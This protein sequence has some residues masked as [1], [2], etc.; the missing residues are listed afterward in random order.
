MKK[1]LGFLLF[2]LLSFYSFAETLVVPKIDDGTGFVR[3][4]TTNDALVNASGL[5]YLLEGQ[6][7]GGTTNNRTKEVY[8]N[9]SGSDSTGNGSFEKPY[10]TIKYAFSTNAIPTSGVNDKWAIFVSPGSYTE[11]NPIT[12]RPHVNL[13]AIGDTSSTRVLANDPDANLFECSSDSFIYGF[14]LLNASNAAA[15]NMT[16]V[17]ICVVRHTS[18]IDCDVGFSMSNQ[19]A[20]ADLDNITAF[21]IGGGTDK[22]IDITAGKSTIKDVAVV[23]DSDVNYLVYATGSNTII[24]IANPVSA[25]A[26]LDYGI[27]AS[28]VASIT[29]SGGRLDGG[30]STGLITAV[31]CDGAHIDVSSLAI[32]N[33]Q[34]GI[35]TTGSDDMHAAAISIENCSTGLLFTG[36]TDAFLSGTSLL[37]CDTDLVTVG[38]GVIFTG[39]GLLLDDNKLVLD[40]LAKH[41]FSHMSNREGDEGL[42]IKGELQVG[43]PEFP[44]ETVMGSGDSYTR[45]MMFYTYDGSTYSNAV[46]AATSASG[47]TVGFPNTNANSAMY[48]AS[49]IVD[50]SGDTLQHPGVKV[51]VDTP[52]TM[53][54]GGVVDFQYY[55]TNDTWESFNYMVTDSGGSYYPYAKNAFHTNGS[56]QIRYDYRMQ[57]DWKKNDPAGLGYSNY[58]ARAVIVSNIVASPLLEQVKLHTDRTEINSD[59][60]MEY[61]GNGRPVKKLPWNVGLLQ[62]VGNTMGAGDV[63][64]SIAKLGVGGDDVEFDSNGDYT[65]FKSQLPWDIDTSCPIGFAWSWRPSATG[66]DVW[67]IRWGKTTEGDEI[68]LGNQAGTDNNIIT[69]TNSVTADLQHWESVN[70]DISDMLSRR[71]DG[72]GDTL[73]ISIES[74]TSSGDPIMLDVSGGYVRWSEGA[75]ITSFLN[76]K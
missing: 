53:G 8:V 10:K 60:F 24:D 7:G 40:P 50:S 73:W 49:S 4:M 14:I 34:V 51:S 69:V 70:I 16:N 65:G 52:I 21:T 43:S 33:S 5:K 38:S 25:S 1:I 31:S 9:E 61:F 12:T 19:Y 66:T 46:D 2:S 55:T 28:D 58:W 56:F 48:V 26:N 68:F 71:E 35:Y 29:M 15:I 75:H 3:T 57:K 76:I 18:I 27:F 41:N 62:D 22:L 72:F 11:D 54:A 39:S 45:G 44:K 74:V 20:I 17:S 64:T 30:S 36:T 67:T 23:G 13:I 59:G 32:K 37:D 42:L 47:S 6:G 63:W